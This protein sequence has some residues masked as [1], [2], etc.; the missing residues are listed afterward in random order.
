[1]YCTGTDIDSDES[2]SESESENKSTSTPQTVFES[3]KMALRH[4]RAFNQELPH[5]FQEKLKIN[6]IDSKENVNIKQLGGIED[7]CANVKNTGISID[8]SNTSANKSNINQSST[9]IDRSN[10]DRSNINNSSTDKSSTNYTKSGK[11]YFDRNDKENKESDVDDGISTAYPSQMSSFSHIRDFGSSISSVPW[12]TYSMSSCAV[13]DCDL[14]SIANT[15]WKDTVSD[16]ESFLQSRSS[17]AATESL[18][19]V[20]KRF[21]Q[22]TQRSDSI[23]EN[24]E[25]NTE[26][27]LER[28]N[29]GTLSAGNNSD[30]LKEGSRQLNTGKNSVLGGSMLES[31]QNQNTGSK[32]S[33]H[34]SDSFEYANSEDRL[35]IRRMEQMWGGNKPCKS[36]QTERKHVLQQRKLKEYLDKR[37]KELPKWESRETESEGSDDS[38]K[39]WTFVK[40]DEKKLQRDTTIRKSTKENNAEKTNNEKIN[41]T[42]RINNSGKVNNAGTMN[43]NG[44]IINTEKTKLSQAEDDFTK[45][46]KPNVQ[47]NQNQST[48]KKI[49]NEMK[50][51]KDVSNMKVNDI[52][53]KKD[54]NALND[55]K[56]DKAINYNKDDKMINDKK[57]SYVNQ[58]Q[59]I[60]VPNIKISRQHSTDGS[61]SDSSPGSTSKSP[62]TIALKQR[63]ILDP[64]LR[65]PFTIVPG[66]YTEQREVAKKFGPIINVFKKPGHHVGP[67]RNPDCLCDHCQGYFTALGYRFRTRSVGESPYD[68]LINWKELKANH[69]AQ[70]ISSKKN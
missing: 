7:T 4:R 32:S 54:D 29:L 27:N 60:Q 70:N 5:R 25:L 63:L 67:V 10:I 26:G 64:K 45:I 68:S 8:K 59:S 37:L 1:M 52:N 9:N 57:E 15:S 38:E 62:S 17:L 69:S 19:F 40:D 53:G 44:E 49:N 43:N 50:F 34:P 23:D 3:K 18:D 16:M 20:P 61:L 6:N 24:V 13:P 56:D 39:G 55:N 48:I 65:A 2:S 41:N 30:L 28:R 51:E 36:P 22:I 21:S 12:S 33:V 11:E 47:C 31:D 35:R 58:K 46:T 42:E 14:D 66:I